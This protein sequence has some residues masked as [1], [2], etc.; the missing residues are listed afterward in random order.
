MKKSKNMIE[1]EMEMIHKINP[2]IFGKEACSIGLV[3]CP[4][5]NKLMKFNNGVWYCDCKQKSR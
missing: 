5:C 1:E 2:K 4:N 3:Y